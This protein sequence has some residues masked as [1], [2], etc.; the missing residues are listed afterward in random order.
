MAAAKSAALRALRLIDPV[1]ALGLAAP[2][3][4]MR[5]ARQVR[6]ERLPIT[7]RTLLS[8]GIMPLHDHYYDPQFRPNGLTPDDLLQDRP[9]P[10]IDLRLDAQ[11]SLLQGFRFQAELAGLPFAQPGP[12]KGTY[13]FDN[14]FFERMDG[15]LWY[16]ML[17]TLKP[18]RIIEVG[19]GFST[20]MARHA[21]A[22]NEAEGAPPAEHVCIEPF[23]NAWLEATGARVV[24]Q[25]VERVDPALFGTLGANDVLFI[26]SSHVIRPGGDVTTE[27]LQILPRLAPGVVAHLHDI[28]TPKD[29]PWHWLFVEHRLWNEQ[30]MLEA[31]LT[32]NPHFEV[33]LGVRHAWSQ[34]ETEVRAAC[35]EIG[36]QA[37]GT[38][39]YIRR[40][41]G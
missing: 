35:V 10:G 18:R 27:I 6:L 9:L 4:A 7:Q 8:L 21:L 25:P 28:F 5:L 2:A 41:G 3:Y 1:L 36:G 15:S 16:A 33:M 17:R 23:E 30:Y 13:W 32:Q 39:F 38:S 22:R 20:L 31:L 26:D 12:A 29:Y 19:S 24:R 34:A 37:P 14:G 40:I 11:R